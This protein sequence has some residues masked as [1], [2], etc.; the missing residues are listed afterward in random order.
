[1][2]TSFRL[3]CL[4]HKDEVRG[5]CG[6]TPGHISQ[7]HSADPLGS[8]HLL[9]CLGRDHVHARAP[10][11]PHLSPF[12]PLLILLQ[13]LCSS[14]MT[15]SNPT[16]LLLVL[17]AVPVSWNTLHHRCY[18]SP[19]Q[20]APPGSPRPGWTSCACGFLASPRSIICL[21]PLF[22]ARPPSPS[23]HCILRTPRVSVA[24]TQWALDKYI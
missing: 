9:F 17:D 20:H 24:Y 8:L 6:A 5:P 1:M 3:P 13:P 2:D 18:A 16:L 19:S 10:R 7:S 15:G 12:F 14:S 21:T 4:C 11:E 22:P 23:S